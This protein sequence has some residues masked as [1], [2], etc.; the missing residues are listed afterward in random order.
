MHSSAAKSRNFARGVKA[1]QGRPVRLEN[2]SRQISLQATERFPSENMQ[3]NGDQ[4][5]V[6]AVEQLVRAGDANHPI[7]E[8]AASVPDGPDLRIGADCIANLVVAC[9]KLSLEV[10][11][12]D[13]LVPSQDVHPPNQVRDVVGNDEIGAVALEC[14]DRAGPGF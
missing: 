14:L 8:V 5:A 9:S 3:P 10:L 6:R 2:T 13:V 7:A 1:W 12:I 4:R 11:R